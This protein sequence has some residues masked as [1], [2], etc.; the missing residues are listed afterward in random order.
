MAQAAGLGGSVGREAQRDAERLEEIGV[1]E[2]HPAHPVPGRVGGAGGPL[3]DLHRRGVQDQHGRVGV[4]H[5]RPEA[6]GGEPF[7]AQHLGASGQPADHPVAERVDVEHGQRGQHRVGLREAHRV[8]DEPAQAQEVLVGLLAELGHAGGAR[9]VH[10]AGHIEPVPPQPG[11]I[12]QPVEPGRGRGWQHAP[13]GGGQHAPVEP[14]GVEVGGGAGG[15]RRRRLPSRPHH[16]VRC[17]LFQHLGQQPVGVVGVDQGDLGPGHHQGQPG[18][19]VGVR[20]GADERHPP[21]QSRARLLQHPGR[22]QRPAHCLPERGRGLAGHAEAGIGPSPHPV[23]D[24]LGQVPHR[25]SLRP[26]NWQRGVPFSAFCAANSSG[27]CCGVNRGPR[28]LLLAAPGGPR[29]CAAP[30]ASLPPPS[31]PSCRA[32]SVRSRCRCTGRGPRSGRTPR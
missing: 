29:S 5:Q 31:A 8:G 19:E 13:V 7:E 17:E 3:E 28:S 25:T 2:E 26:R 10:P 18:C 32:G 12:V 30:P 27:G 15:H 16:C 1:G 11:R 14:A 9:R 23:A 24:Q 4:T 6:A 20:R 22:A 21:A